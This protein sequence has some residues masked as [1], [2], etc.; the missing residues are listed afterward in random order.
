MGFSLRG[1]ARSAHSKMTQMSRRLMLCCL[2]FS[3]AAIALQIMRSARA[4]FSPS[5]VLAGCAQVLTTLDGV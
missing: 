2:S 4:H 1:S 3:L 5:V